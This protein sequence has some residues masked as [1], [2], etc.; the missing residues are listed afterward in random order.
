[1]LLTRNDASALACQFGELNSAYR[2]C[3]EIKDSH[4]TLRPR[5]VISDLGA[6][7]CCTS[8]QDQ[9]KG[10]LQ[11]GVEAGESTISPCGTFSA[12]RGVWQNQKAHLDRSPFVLQQQLKCCRVGS[13]F[14]TID[15]AMS[16]FSKVLFMQVANHRDGH[17]RPSLVSTC[18]QGIVAS[19]GCRTRNL[20]CFS[21]PDT[22]ASSQYPEANDVMTSDSYQL[23]TVLLS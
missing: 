14:A 15:V 20:P 11:H 9:C 19:F 22:S 17:C 8:A 4:C 13:L 18:L 3:S 6:Y 2:G 7:A 16:N 10:H 1:M 5:V 23:V 12:V 21:T